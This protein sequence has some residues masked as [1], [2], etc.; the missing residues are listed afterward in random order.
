M[1]AESPSSSHFRTIERQDSFDLGCEPIIGCEQ[2]GC[3]TVVRPQPK[4][5]SV[6]VCSCATLSTPLFKEEA[7]FVDPAAATDLLMSFSQAKTDTEFESASG[8]EE[9]SSH[10]KKL[11]DSAESL[12]G[13]CSIERFS[14]VSETTSPSDING[15]AQKQPVKGSNDGGN[16]AKSASRTDFA[17]QDHQC[18]LSVHVDQALISS[19]AVSEGDS[20]IEPCAEGGKDD[21][22]PRSSG[23]SQTSKGAQTDVTW[24]PAEQKDKKKG[25]VLFL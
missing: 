2:V 19:A 6:D 1:S 14:T 20:G 21:C 24:T 11:M 12:S 7:S 3:I 18:L 15:Y 13:R 22:G 17:D 4:T 8:N 5:Q 10:L 23:G 9:N 25:D 16:L